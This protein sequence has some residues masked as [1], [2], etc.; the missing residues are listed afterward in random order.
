MPLQLASTVVSLAD[1]L[2]GQCSRSA[3]PSF[4]AAIIDAVA[5]VAYNLALKVAYN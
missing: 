5:K 4:D 1:I 2:F 3:I